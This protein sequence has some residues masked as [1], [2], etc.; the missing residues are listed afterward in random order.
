LGGIDD[1]IPDIDQ[2]GIGFGV[3]LVTGGLPILFLIE[4]NS[5]DQNR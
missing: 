2:V 4:W 5:F 3:F 1:V